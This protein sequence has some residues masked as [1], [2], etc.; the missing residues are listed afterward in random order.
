MFVLTKIQKKEGLLP[1]SIM[2]GV[3]LR[4]DLHL[5]LV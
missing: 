5:H 1:L 3:S 4:L 2:L